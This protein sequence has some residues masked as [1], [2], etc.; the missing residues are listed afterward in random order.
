MSIFILASAGNHLDCSQ[1][2]CQNE[3]QCLL[4]SSSLSPKTFSSGDDDDDLYFIAN[5]NQQ[6]WYKANSQ[7]NQQGDGNGQLL[8]ME[9]GDV[10][11]RLS[12]Q[13]FV[14]S[15]ISYEDKAVAGF[16]LGQSTGSNKD[17][18]CPIIV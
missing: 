9:P 17:N 16:W 13:L 5:G 3:G 11:A 8:Q 15:Y 1:N 14:E 7:C 6:N 10:K 2:Y 18:F 12:A 4:M